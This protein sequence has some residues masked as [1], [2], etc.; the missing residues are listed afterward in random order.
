MSL[1]P[2]EHFEREWAL[3]LLKEAIQRLKS[4]QSESEEGERRFEILKVFLTGERPD[5]TYA[6]L[7]EKLRISESAARMAVTRLRARYRILIREEILKTVS[8]AQDVEDEIRELFRA[9]SR[10]K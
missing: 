2:E 9:L 8:S 3:T 1:S 10:R 4:E 6:D 5:E 7:C